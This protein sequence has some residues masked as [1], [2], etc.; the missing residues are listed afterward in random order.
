MFESKIEEK[1]IEEAHLNWRCIVSNHLAQSPLSVEM[2]HTKSDQIV[3]IDIDG[4][5][6]VKCDKCFY[7]ISS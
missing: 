2:Q 4:T 3:Y 5:R 6:W 7:P 1:V